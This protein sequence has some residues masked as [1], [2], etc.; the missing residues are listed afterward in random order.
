MP[1]N[2]LSRRRF[3]AAGA[4]AMVGTSLPQLRTMSKEQVIRTYYSGWEKKD[5]SVVDHVLA[6]SFTFTSPNND[7]HISKAAFKDRCWPQIA[8]IER[9][10]LQRVVPGDTDAFV[11]YECHTTKNTIFRNVEYFRFAGDQVS[12]IECYFGSPLG[13]PSASATGKPA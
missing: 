11:L 9:F 12:A 8:F 7:D 5:W 6:A 2:F 13:F 1:L 4:S 10:D 3:V